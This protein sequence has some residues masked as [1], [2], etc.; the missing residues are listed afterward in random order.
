MEKM[1]V[2]QEG[3][4]HQEE[5]P[6]AEETWKEK[7]IAVRNSAMKKHS[8]GGGQEKMATEV[9]G[10]ICFLHEGHMYQFMDVRSNGWCL[11]D[12]LCQ[13]KKGEALREMLKESTTEEAAV[14]AT[15]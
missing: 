1:V 10:M 2:V 11:Y 14:T 12:S 3:W 5:V 8:G 15:D 7:N 9:P 4:K 6:G 13:G